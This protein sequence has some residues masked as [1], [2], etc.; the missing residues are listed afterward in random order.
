MSNEI[1]WARANIPTKNSRGPSIWAR[2]IPPGLLRE[3]QANPGE[4]YLLG[5][6]GGQPRPFHTSDAQLLA[7]AC[8]RPF[9]VQTRHVGK[10]KRAVW[11]SNDPAHWEKVDT[12]RRN[13]KQGKTK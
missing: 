13:R 4:T 2:T 12:R 9:R 1:T 3:M 11:V 8:P 5:G 7:K 10:D 6:P